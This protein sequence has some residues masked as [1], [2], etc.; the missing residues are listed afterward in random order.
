MTDLPAPSS[1]VLE[2]QACGADQITVVLE[3]PDP[4]RAFFD[5]TFDG[6]GVTHARIET[7]D[8]TGQLTSQQVRPVVDGVVSYVVMSDRL[9]DNGVNTLVIRA[10][11]EDG[12]QSGPAAECSFL[13]H[14]A[15]GRALSVLPFLAADAIYPDGK[16]GR[17]GAGVP[18]AFVVASPLTADA[19]SFA[20]GTSTS[21]TDEPTEW[22]TVPVAENVV[23]P[24]VPTTP[25]V[26]TLW[27]AEVD[28]TGL[29]GV[30]TMRSAKVAE[31]G[32]AQDAPPVVSV[33][34]LEDTLPGDGMIPLR[35][36]LTPDLRTRDGIMAARGAVTLRNGTTDLARATF[37]RRV[38]DVLISESQV[39]TGFRDLRVEYEQF[40]GAD[41]ATDT[42]RICGGSCS[43]TGG[44]GK[45]TTWH[46]NPT[47]EPHLDAEASGFFPAPQ[48]YTYQWFRDGKAIAR[49]TGAQYVSPP[50]DEGHRIGVRVTAHG[51][52]M[53]PRS[54]TSPAV[55]IGDRRSLRVYYG[56]K[57]TESRWVPDYTYMPN[58]DGQTAGSI[59]R[60]ASVEALFSSVGGVGYTGSVFPSTDSDIWL[61]TEGYVQGRGWV[62][63]QRKD[64]T[65]YVGSI[66]QNRRLEAFHTKL[67][68]PIAP[69]YDVWYRAYVPKYGW[70]GWA[71]NGENSGT[72]GFGYR[73]EAVEMRVLPK[74][75]RRSASG[76]GNA[77][78]YDKA[79]QNQV[80]VQP[81]LRPT[82]WKT[83]VHGGSTAGLTSTSQ[84]LN[85][86][87]V[88]VNGQRYSGGVQVSA[89][90]EGDGWRSWVGDTKV[91]GTYHRTDRTSAY[92][93]RLTGEMAKQYDIYYRTYLAGTGWLGW[94]RNGG[95]AG[96]ESYTK[97]VTAVQVVLVK[98]GERPLMSGYGRAAY[99]R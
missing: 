63:I 13:L 53:T 24:F 12:T 1:I 96:T 31:P 50:T 16:F 95:G 38:K 90:V 92:R 36:T 52:R 51:P 59:G 2:D 9:T 19:V 30:A 55:L 43:F 6:P 18:G 67:G 83:A 39:G 84:R 35:L 40:P 54:V 58:S 91:A 97:R 69:Y 3:R 22:T 64:Y 14:R 27:V 75:T 88:D 5:A 4:G 15:P 8:A 34:E 86:V 66:G 45:I 37:D 82:G 85:A 68:G 76:T 65:Y 87:R 23:I 99:R 46:G 10:Q 77:P 72:T 32:A 33:A 28:R 74:G 93:M 48:S 62:G 44:A 70:L 71:K 80:T 60:G 78:F 25:G 26:H 79:T 81:Y 20:Y 29:L 11:T 49:A 42:A 73:I 98:K 89:K 7:L 94:A 61:E 47:T 56:V 21:Y 57:M 17:G 41:V